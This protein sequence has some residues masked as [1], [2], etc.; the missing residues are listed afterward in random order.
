[1][2]ALVFLKISVYGISVPVVQVQAYCMGFG[3]AF[4]GLSL[5]RFRRGRVH[6]VSR[7]VVR[8]GVRKRVSVYHSQFKEADGI[9]KLL[10]LSG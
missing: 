5:V 7:L 2:N 3:F 4:A 8:V 1:M 9:P 6:P 10:C